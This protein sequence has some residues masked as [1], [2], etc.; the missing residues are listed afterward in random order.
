MYSSFF[1]L[2]IGMI[3]L[4]TT[5][6]GRSIAIF[7]DLDMGM[8]GSDTFFSLGCW[9]SGVNKKKTYE[10]RAKVMS[11]TEAGETESS[12]MLSVQDWI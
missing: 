4:S 10:S 11:E 3:P 2:D 1:D 5:S 9:D 6:P 12:N 7:F 8:M